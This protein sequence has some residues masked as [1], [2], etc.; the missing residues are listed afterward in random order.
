MHRVSAVLQE[1]VQR[2]SFCFVDKIY[3][4]LLQE[5]EE[6]RR[7][8]IAQYNR[9]FRVIISCLLYGYV[10]ILNCHYIFDLQ[11]LRSTIELLMEFTK[12]G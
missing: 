8:S 4:C 7:S 2:C 12:Y 10:D 11:V 5:D 1:M 9:K 3:L 6:K